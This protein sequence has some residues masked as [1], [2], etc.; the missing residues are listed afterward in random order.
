MSSSAYIVQPFKL[1][2]LGQ[3]ANGLESSSHNHKGE[4]QQVP[5]ILVKLIFGFVAPSRS[6]PAQEI[7]HKGK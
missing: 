3:S 6:H 7:S 2:M 4:L 1:D 5:T